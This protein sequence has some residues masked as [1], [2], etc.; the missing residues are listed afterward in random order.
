M[1]DVRELT[2]IIGVL[3]VTQHITYSL[4]KEPAF[5]S[6]V[7]Q[8]LATIGA[9]VME[10]QQLSVRFLLYHQVHLILIVTIPLIKKHM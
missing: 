7:H 2:Q 1:K 6:L 9:Q 8:H 4:Q 5:Q 10:E 3:N